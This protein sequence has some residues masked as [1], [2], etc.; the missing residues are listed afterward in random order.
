[1]V[2]SRPAIVSVR[3]WLRKI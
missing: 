3:G 1:M 2:R